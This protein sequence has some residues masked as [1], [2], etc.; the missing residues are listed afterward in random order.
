MDKELKAYLQSVDKC[1]KPMTASERADI[2]REMESEILDLQQAGLTTREIL[3]RLGPP[4]EFAKAYLQ[5]LLTKNHDIRWNRIL[6]TF[7]F[8]SLVGFSGL[9]VVPTLGILAPVLMLCGVICPVAGLIKLIGHIIG[10]EVPF[11]MFQ[12]GSVT[13]SPWLAFPASAIIGI[14]LFLLGKGSWHL[15]LRYLQTASEVGKKI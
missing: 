1:L 7:A 2:L 6:M 11:I 15:L 13:L 8:C 9:F 5:D 4:K 3:A 10:R 12:F 14:L